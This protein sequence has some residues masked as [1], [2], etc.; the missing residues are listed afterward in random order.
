MNGLGYQACLDSTS[1]LRVKGKCIRVLSRR[2]DP[3]FRKMSGEH[4]G[5]EFVRKDQITGDDKKQLTSS[6]QKRVM[7]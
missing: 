2:M 4:L 5:G 6:S 1:G 7:A 3:V